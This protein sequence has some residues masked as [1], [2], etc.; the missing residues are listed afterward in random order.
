MSVRF[1]FALFLVALAAHQ[2]KASVIS[3]SLSAVNGPFPSIVNGELSL[4]DQEYVTINIASDPSV[5]AADQTDAVINYAVTYSVAEETDCFHVVYP[6]TVCGGGYDYQVSGQGFDSGTDGAYGGTD[7]YAE[8]IGSPTG[9]LYLFAGSYTFLALADALVSGNGSMGTMNQ[10]Y[11]S[12]TGVFTVVA[13]EVS[14]IPEPG[15]M[16]LFLFVV[17]GCLA[18]WA[19]SVKALSLSEKTRQ[20]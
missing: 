6:P 17:V 2:A 11:G 15:T 12:I 3:F 4:Y 1:S 14:V 19:Y 5:V 18:K 7:V 10:T 20:Q 8:P 9:T 16:S 13:G